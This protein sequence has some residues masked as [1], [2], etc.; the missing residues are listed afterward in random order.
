M[1]YIDEKEFKKHISSKKFNNVYVIFGDEKY[2]VKHYTNELVTAVAGKE[3][4]E[5]AFHQLDLSADVQSVADA[6]GVVPFMAEYNCVLLKDY[7]VNELDKHSFESLLE[8]VKSVPDTTVLIFSYLTISGKKAK[9]KAEDEEKKE[10]TINCFRNLCTTV[11]KMG[12][13]CVAE[14]NMRTAVSLE[15]Q[16]S[17]W[18]AKMGKKLSLPLASKLIYFCG[19]DLK[20]LKFELDKVCAYAADAEELTLEMVE[21]AVV[22]KLEAK[23][24]DMADSVIY[25]KTDK[26]YTELYQLFAMKEDVRGIVRVLGFVYTDLYRARVTEESGALMKDTATFF[27]SGK[28]EWALKKASSKSARL[29]TSALRESLSAITELSAKLNSVTMNEEAAVEK[30]IADL[31]L[32]AARES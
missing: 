17:K 5:F 9:E 4:G 13:G 19:N 8:V 16:L 3:P 12:M 7:D 28:R 2:L 26:A 6:V 27:N 32:I 10:K 14:I 31:V 1:A 15:H 23:V 25:G 11:E 29:S 18:A 21:A 30:L 22:K 24:Y 20:T